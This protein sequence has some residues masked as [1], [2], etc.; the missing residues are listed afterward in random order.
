MKIAVTYEDGNVFGHFGHT[1]QFKIYQEESGS[2]TQSCIV[3]TQG[4]GH[5]ALAAFLA[6]NGVDTL[7]CGG[8]G[9]GARQ[10]LSEAGIRLYAGVTGDADQAASALLA[11]TLIYDP[12]VVCSHHEHE[13]A[14][15]TNHEHSRCNGHGCGGHHGV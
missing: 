12:D 8:I 11:G 13:H 4:A 10:A 6:E 7:I 3:D 14:D 15:C 5:G 2:I 1:Q 9:M